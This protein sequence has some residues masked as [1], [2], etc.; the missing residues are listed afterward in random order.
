VKKSNGSLVIV[1]FNYRVGLFGF[2]ANKDVQEDGDL[3]V[4]LLDQRA[5]LRWVQ[6]YIGQVSR[7]TGRGWQKTDYR[8]G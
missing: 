3:N 8:L 4:G 7:S 2:L 5:L 1:E 6:R